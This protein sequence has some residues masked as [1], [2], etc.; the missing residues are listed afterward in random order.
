[1]LLYLP[2]TEC[3]TSKQLRASDYLKGA[4]YEIKKMSIA[5]RRLSTWRWLSHQLADN[6][7]DGQSAGQAHT[8]TKGELLHID[9]MVGTALPAAT[10]F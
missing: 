7:V 1:M 8:L 9:S 3:Q 2:C 10:A 6:G 5:S 4:S